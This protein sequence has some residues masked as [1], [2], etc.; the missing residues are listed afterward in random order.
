MGC[1]VD[2]EYFSAVPPKG[3]EVYKYLKNTKA[4][5]ILFYVMGTLTGISP[6]FLTSELR[7]ILDIVEHGNTYRLVLENL[8]STQN[9]DLIV[10]G[11]RG[12][13]IMKEILLGSVSHGVILHAPCPIMVVR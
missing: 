12:L 8:Q 2:Y 4:K 1:F 13:G 11:A 5:K 6:R 10:I 7:D 3:D 9:I